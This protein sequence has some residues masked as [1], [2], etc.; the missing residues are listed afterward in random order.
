M[1]LTNQCN[2]R[3]NFCSNDDG[4]AVPVEPVKVTEMSGALRE[5][6]EADGTL[7]DFNE[8]YF[9]GGEPLLVIDPLIEIAKTLPKSV[10]INISTNG[11]L[12][13]EVALDRLL[14][15]GLKG[16]KLSYDTVDLK[17][18]PKIRIGAT[19]SDLDRIETNIRRAVRKGVAVYLRSTVGRQN[20]DELSDIYT[21][22]GILGVACLQVKPVLSSGRAK[23]C[24]D[25]LSVTES[26]FID[27]LAI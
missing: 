27:A 20:I 1:K 8:I 4:A 25:R 7:S 23:V 11:L 10:S 21:S 12:L 24:M 9:T 14:A 2:Y 22:A 5:L 6:E 19:S 15:V 17:R 26:E 3:C 13:E 16:I 18:L